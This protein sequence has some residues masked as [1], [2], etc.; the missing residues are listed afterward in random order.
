MMT[1]VCECPVCGKE[2]EVEVK[3]DDFLAWRLGGLAQN[4]FPYLSATER[5]C[6]ISGM[7]PK[8]QDK[9]FGIEEEEEEMTEEDLYFAN[10]SPEELEEYLKN[11]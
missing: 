7:C 6:L 8:C 10:L 2:Y 4:C 5:E 1:I 3:L 9:M 11:L